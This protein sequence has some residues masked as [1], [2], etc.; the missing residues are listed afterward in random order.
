MPHP[1]ICDLVREFVESHG[2]QEH[3]MMTVFA[4]SLEEFADFY[5]ASCID[6]D[7]IEDR[8][9]DILDNYTVSTTPTTIT[10]VRTN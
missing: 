3:V 5:C 8:W 6:L 2:I 7:T 10:L 1:F 9:N 4:K